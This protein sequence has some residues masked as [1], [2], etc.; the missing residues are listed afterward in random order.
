MSIPPGYGGHPQQLKAMV[1]IVKENVAPLCDVKIGA[2]SIAIAQAVYLSEARGRKAIT[3][4]EFK[5]Y[6][7]KFEKNPEE[8]RRKLLEAGGER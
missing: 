6:A 8:L 2:E 4:S 1:R 7:K 3:L 5:E